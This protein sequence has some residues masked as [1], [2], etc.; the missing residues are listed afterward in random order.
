MQDNISDNLHI[1][2]NFLNF[3]IIY[4]FIIIYLCVV[5]SIRVFKRLILYYFFSID[6]LSQR[7]DCHQ[8]NSKTRIYI[9]IQKKN[10]KVAKSVELQYDLI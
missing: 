5:L 2:K 6:S 1:L 10:I 7:K 9:Q 4:Y 3:N 8:A